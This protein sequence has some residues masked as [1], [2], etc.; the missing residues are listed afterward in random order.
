MTHGGVNILLIAD[1][2]AGLQT[3][4][5]LARSLHRVVGVMA[6]PA[7]ESAGGPTVWQ[8]AEQMGFRTW[9]AQLVRDA[10]FAELLQAENVQLLL[11]V[12]SLFVIQEAILQVPCF[13]AFNLHP[14]PLPRYAGLNAPSWAI[15][16][17]ESTHGVTMH[18]MRAGIDTGPIAYQ[19]RCDIDERDTGFS[20]S[21]KCATHGMDLVKRLL[22]TAAATPAS[23]P[24]IEQDL[25]QREYFGRET[26]LDGWIDW[27]RPAREIHNFVRAADYSPFPSPWKTPRSRL[28][29]DEVAFPR[30]VRTGVPCDAPPGAI[31][32]FSET[33]AAWIAC[34]DEWLAV[35]HLLVSGQKVHAREL[36]RPGYHLREAC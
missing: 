3:L 10:S 26:P 25:S 18:W 2:S 7:K 36:F 1:E 16:R 24:A 8:A 14:G 29:D 31:G 23:I 20:L 17:N 6:S 11:N 28:G 19:T 13:G 30:V 34:G 5:L 15:Y 4:K 35:N 22:E 33:G 27:T 21:A 32:S 9:P 12:H